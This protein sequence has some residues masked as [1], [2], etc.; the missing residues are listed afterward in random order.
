MK[1]Y[2][3]KTTFEKNAT[4]G[5]RMHSDLAQAKASIETDLNAGAIH[6]DLYECTPVPFEAEHGYTV[7]IGEPA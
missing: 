6:V 1:K 3:T 4:N 2:L 5:L 7:Y